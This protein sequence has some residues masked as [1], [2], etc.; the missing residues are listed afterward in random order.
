MSISHIIDTLQQQ[1][2][3]YEQLLEM[4]AGKKALIMQN[5]IVQLNVVTQKERLLTAEAESLEQNRMLM[6]ARY[7]IDAGFRSRSG[8]LSD[9]IKLLSNSEDKQLLMGLQGT[10]TGVLL[11]L[12]Q[13][14]R[15]NQ[16]LIQQSL[17]FINFSIDLM[18]ED[19]NE[20]LLYQH[21]MKQFAGN[22]NNRIFDSRA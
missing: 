9:L 16:Q 20:D 7:F 19:P 14:N 12:K 2:K 3:L 5:N 17:D 13:I 1:L 15:L 10:L 4:E 11:E 18:V 21:P 8:L 6:T 22:R